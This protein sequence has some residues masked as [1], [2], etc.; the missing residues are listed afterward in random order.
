MI[1]KLNRFV[2]KN[3]PKVYCRM[4]DEIRWALQRQG[5]SGFASI[6]K[7]FVSRHLM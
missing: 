3:D 6:T 2:K 7:I 1:N 5:F 4:Q